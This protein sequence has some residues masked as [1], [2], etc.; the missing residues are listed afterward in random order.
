MNKKALL[1]P[2]SIVTGS[3]ALAAGAAVAAGEV[4]YNFALKKKKKRKALGQLAK[5]QTSDQPL[6]AQGDMRLEWVDEVN[7]KDVTVSSF[8]GLT[9]HAFLAENPG[10][11][12][13]FA[14]ILHGYTCHAREMGFYGEKFFEKGFSVLLPSAR[15]HDES[16]GEFIDMGWYQRLDILDWIRMI[17]QKYNDPQI[18][19]MGVSMGG[20][21]VMMASGENLPPNV[22]CAIEDCGFSSIKEQFDHTLKNMMQIP[23]Q[24]LM[25]CANFVTHIKTGIDINKDGYSTKCLKNCRIPMLFIHGTADKY[26]PFWMLDKNYNA[27][28]GPKQKYIVV[29][30]PHASSAWHGGQEYW[31]KVFAFVESFIS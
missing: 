23:P 8:D 3:A 22:V 25:S 4:F 18:V 16:E 24:P 11:T 7:A 17:N 27:H 28:P 20:A 5:N 14:I 13:K 6:Q 12:D 2:L 26:V 19:L 29:G 31:D 21:A 15:C 9:L 30:A 10:H 1:I